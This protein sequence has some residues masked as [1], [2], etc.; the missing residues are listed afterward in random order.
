VVAF[1]DQLM[2]FCGR[3]LTTVDSLLHSIGEQ[4]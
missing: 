2:F 4:C 1:I 3:A